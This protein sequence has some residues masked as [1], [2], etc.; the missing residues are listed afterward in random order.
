MGS[1]AWRAAEAAARAAGVDLRPLAELADAG[2]IVDVMV[3][4][5][6][7]TIGP[8]SASSARGRR[9]TPAARAAASAAR[10]ASDPIEGRVYRSLP[11]EGGPQRRRRISGQEAAHGG[12]ALA[13]PAESRQVHQDQRHDHQRERQDRKSTRLNSSHVKISY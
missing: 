12:V 1:E 5:M 9:S 7:S 10:Q 8:A 3:A 2:P 13:Q 6:T 4:T 11:P